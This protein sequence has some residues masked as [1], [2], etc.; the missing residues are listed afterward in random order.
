MKYERPKQDD[1][2][3]IYFQYYPSY[4]SGYLETYPSMFFNKKD[5][6]LD[7]GCNK[8]LF[9]MYC[10][11]ESV[12]IDIDKLMLEEAKKKGLNVI[13]HD[14]EEKLPF[15]DN[16]FD[17]VNIRQCI[18]HISNPL[19]VLKEI[20]RVLKPEGKIVLTFHD[21]KHYKWNWFG[22]PFH[23]TPLTKNSMGRLMYLAG[24]RD[25]KIINFRNGLFDM[26]KLFKIGINPKIIKKIIEIVSL[27][28]NHIFVVEG[29]KS[30]F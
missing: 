23:I 10:S 12:G 17:A 21:L 15:D 6:T 28:R 30:D 2:H 29:R 19:K 25:Y 20:Y 26:H 16:E 27:I 7:I 22:N 3:S 9:L 11:K 13:Y 1:K 8:G 24:F 18:E 14:A 4:E 5:K